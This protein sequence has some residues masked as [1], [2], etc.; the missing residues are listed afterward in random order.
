MILNLS[1]DHHCPWVNNCIG[2][3]NYGHF[4]RF[5]FYVDVTCSYHLAMVTQRVLDSFAPPYWVPLTSLIRSAATINFCFFLLCA[6]R[7]ICERVYFYSFEL[8]FLYPGHRHG[9]GLQVCCPTP[10]PFIPSSSIPACT[11]ST[12]YSETPRQ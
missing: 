1:Q 2:H 9:W 4:I 7:A 11:I 10:C 8:H 5:L 3:F 12:A 6:G